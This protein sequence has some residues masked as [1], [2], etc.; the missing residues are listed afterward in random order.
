LSANDSLNNQK[1]TC[2]VICPIGKEGSETR[3][4]SD[5]LL[6]YILRPVVEEK[7]GY[8]MYRGDDIRQPG[9]ITNQVLKNL[10]QSDL[11][12][13]DLSKKNGNVFYEL[14]VRHITKK[15][16]IHL[17]DE[18]EEK[19]FDLA[20][21]R[22]IRFKLD[23][24][25]AKK[26]KKELEDYIQA[27]QVDGFLAENPLSGILEQ[28]GISSLVPPTVQI[29]DE[30]K[31]KFEQLTLNMKDEINKTFKEMKLRHEIPSKITT[32]PL[33][34]IEL[35]KQTEN[36]INALNIIDKSLENMREVISQRPTEFDLDANL[37]K[38]NLYY[39]QGKYN[40]AIELFNKIL[41]N[42]PNNLD[43]LKNRAWSLLM[44]GR[45]EEVDTSLEKIKDISTEDAEVLSI[46]SQ[47]SL[48]R[49][50][51]INSLRLSTRALKLDP[52]YQ[53][54]IYLKGIALVNLS[55][56]KEA[57][58]LLE[59]VKDEYPDDLALKERLAVAYK[60]VGRMKDSEKMYEQIVK[61]AKPANTQ[62]WVSVGLA[63]DGLKKYE[64]AV[65]AYDNAL[66]LDP[67]Y[68]YALYD[69]G[70]ALHSLN[71]YEEALRVCD[72][73]LKINPQDENCLLEKGD[74]LFILKRYKE[75]HKVYKEVLKINSKNQEARSRIEEIQKLV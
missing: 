37:E 45:E 50:D 36:K 74:I 39:Y 62:E 2:F 66:E 6:E 24:P 17:I 31:A 59:K 48:N 35:P 54:A 46:R 21:T 41:Q 42:Y 73:A 20:G 51:S 7:F 23:L 18:E 34:E 43:A 14:A 15:P 52:E 67:T 38:G 27:T 22:I 44:A 63:L 75:A 69:K 3:Q 32:G 19:P 13:A 47:A 55:R 68:F 60:S 9:I 72:E 12:I 8:S 26:A 29:D 10:L 61:T 11:V 16:F 56:D 25:G 53:H 57:I 1:K 4:H 70:L 71:R 65:E 64:E 49:G 28:L 58:P 30:L 33:K 5:D 40:E